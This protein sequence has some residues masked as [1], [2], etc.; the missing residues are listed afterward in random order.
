MDR[1]ALVAI[2]DIGEITADYIIDFFAHP[3]TRELIDSLKAAGVVTAN[4]EAEMQSSLLEGLTFVITGTLEGMSRDEASELIEANGGKTSGS[5]SKKTS[6]VLAGEKAGSKLIKA[7]S[8][9]VPVISLD[10][11]LKMIEQE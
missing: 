9:G 3:Q 2:G 6:Y 10:E 1:D 4:E 5:V 11:L 7:Q 8:L